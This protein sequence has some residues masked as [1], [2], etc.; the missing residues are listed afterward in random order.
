MSKRCFQ[1]LLYWILPALLV[2]CAATGTRQQEDPASGTAAEEE[3]ADADVGALSPEIVYNILMGEI[4]LQRR[5]LDLAY[6]HQLQGALL[7]ND[8]E[9]AERATRIAIHQKDFPKAMEA[10]E[11]WVE[12]AP[13]NF[14][15]RVMAVTVSLWMQ[16]KERALE[17]LQKVVTLS[18]AQGED[19]FLHA[20]AAVT[21]ARESRMGLQLMQQV[22]AGY[23][24]DSRAH[25]A[26]ALVAVVVKDYGVAERE[27]RQV[28]KMSPEMA[29][30]HVL[31][32]RILITRKQGEEAKRVLREAA[33]RFPEH[34]S[35]NTAYGRLLLEL[36]EIE[37]AYAQFKK[38]RRLL[39]E[40][41][42]ILL[43]LGILAIQLDRLD[44]ARSYLLKLSRWGKNGDEAAFYLGRIEEQEKRLDKAV[45]WYQ[46]VT[47]DKRMRVEA[48][49]RIAR[50]L[51]EQ[52]E[53]AEAREILEALRRE[54][55]ARSE[56]IYL[57]EGGILGNLAASEVVLEHYDKA[58]KA[59][60]D[61]SDLLYARGLYASTHGRLDSAE[62]DLRKIIL[63]DENHADALNALGYTLADQ[64]DRYQEALGY[65]ERALTLNPES[66]AILDSMGWVQFKLGDNEQALE[67]LRRA[68]EMLPDGEIAAH[69][70]EV[71]WVS[72]NKDEARKIWREALERDPENQYLLR[73][74][75]RLDKR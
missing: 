10:V 40:A 3:K 64:T 4:A 30:A 6:E 46:K 52:G 27:A 50:I 20:V 54:V 72:G 60:P 29:K 5:Q 75:E 59:H 35:L 37:A 23:P 58:L 11:S 32:A 19:G 14:Q 48:R 57:V 69:L 71:L 43:S 2:G 13:E 34:K 8:A 26:V 24:D 42:E 53:L 65:I 73:A 61:S 31:L 68:Y 16:E 17:H 63:Q 41:P 56:D 39:P 51:A 38:L 1:K 22:A 74:V 67:Y 44:E 28:V 36:N 66:P 62:Q 25:Y 21:Q 12:L 7:A 55:P 47:T 45:D 70:G 49:M 9:A 33:A 18:E 15:A